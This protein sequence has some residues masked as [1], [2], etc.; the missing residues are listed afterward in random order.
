PDGRHAYFTAG[1][2]GYLTEVDLETN[3]VSRTIETHGKI[4]HMVLVS[5]DNKRLY[6]ANIGSENVSVIDRE[7]GSLIRQITCGEGAEGMA[8]TP[9]G[10][11]LW[12]ANQT[13]GSIT[14]IDLKTHEAIET[15]DCP[16]MPVRIRFA[17]DG[18]LA[19][20]PGWTEVGYLIVI[21]VAS[22]TEVKRIK[23]GSYAIGIELSPDERRAF[24]GCEY[25]DGVHVIDMKSLTLEKVIMTGSGP[26][27]MVMWNQP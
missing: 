10:K 18:K 20:V 1:Q 22:R 27:P 26:D 24:V 6:T 15:F 5:G 4:S 16:G 17:G 12:V 23:V 11:Y 2:T 8:F 3:K 21:D 7:T 13:G 14:I 19:L 9:D 25:N